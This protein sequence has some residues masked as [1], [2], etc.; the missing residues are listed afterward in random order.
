MALFK[1]LWGL[2]E[3]VRH[4]QVFLFYCNFIKI[5]LWHVRQLNYPDQFDRRFAARLVDH[6]LLDRLIAKGL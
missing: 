2:R 1:L 4:R 3:W 6:H 5:P